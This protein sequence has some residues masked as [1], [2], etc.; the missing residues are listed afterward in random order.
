M[1]GAVLVV[2]LL[3]LSQTPVEAPLDDELSADL[4]ASF[5]LLSGTQDVDT[6]NQ[7][8]RTL[9]D[10]DT[11]A[12]HWQAFFHTYFAT[13][14]S[15][16]GR[17]FTAVLGEFWD[18]AIRE[19]TTT[20]E[21]TALISGLC[22]AE[23]AGAGLASIVAD[24]ASVDH[25][26]LGT[27]LAWLQQI[28]SAL[29][30]QHRAA[31]L[32]ALSEPLGGK[33]LDLTSILRPG[34]A[35]RQAEA[36]L[37]MQI[38]LTLR[39]YVSEG[40]AGRTAFSALVALPEPAR[41]FLNRFGILL[42]E[43][44]A[45][46]PQQLDS[47]DSLVRLI[48][49]ELHEIDA[50]IVPEPYDLDPSVPGVVAAGQLVFVPLIPMDSLTNPAEFIPRVAQPVVPEFTVTAAQQI[51]RAIQAV[52]FDRNPTLV[53][54]RDAIIARGRR[55]SVSYLRRFVDPAVYL[56]DPDELLPM[57]AYL[58]FIDSQTAF[59]MAFEYAR[60]KERGALETVLL[61]ADVLSAG[62]NATLLFST[63]PAGMVTGGPTSIGRVHL[64]EAPLALAPA[65]S[66]DYVNS[67]HILG[68]LWAFV[69]DDSGAIQ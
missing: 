21:R 52:Q 42:F 4:T 31:I 27:A 10:T 3:Y 61:L 39:A 36:R 17:P 53:M 8:R 9:A 54:R 28:V 24:R 56:E 47:L 46:D 63:D 38:C 44:G 66:L 18:Y 20:Q 12:N 26:S 5:E 22:A 37:G 1:P 34:P 55:R 67:I 50:I 14:P 58:W 51:F 25:G 60:V 7:V 49:P 45:L 35:D 2:V 29:T 62:G 15:G 41:T 6:A 69:L 48:P 43:N 68:E 59:A 64:G 32:E 11:A 30:P 23:A 13:A 16:G 33:P 40:P 57:A 65:V 19:A